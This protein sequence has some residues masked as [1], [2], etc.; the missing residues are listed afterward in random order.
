MA[1]ETEIRPALSEREWQS[2]HHWIQC[3]DSWSEEAAAK[4]G[5]AEIKAGDGYLHLTSHQHPDFADFSA[6]TD[7]HALAALALCGQPF[8]FTHDD[9]EFVRS[10][11]GS[12]WDRFGPTEY[13]QMA[14]RLQSIADRIAALLPP[15]H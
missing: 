15:K 10:M 1:N 5:V 7:R 13:R 8:G 6:P 12:E 14:V 2:K 9:V 4:S 3:Y 11:E